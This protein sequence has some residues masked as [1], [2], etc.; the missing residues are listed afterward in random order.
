LNDDA[1]ALCTKIERDFLRALLGGCA[2]PISALAN[3]KKE[4]FFS[5]EI[6]YRLMEKKK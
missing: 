5:G 6:F 1:T 2:T 3:G 4:I